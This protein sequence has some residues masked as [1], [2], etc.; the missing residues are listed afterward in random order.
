MPVEN[1]PD[2]R[3]VERKDDGLVYFF[4]IQTLETRWTIE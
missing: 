4:N 3:R 2:W 1:Q